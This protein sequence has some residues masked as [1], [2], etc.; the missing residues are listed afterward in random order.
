MHT[1]SLALSLLALSPSLAA[2]SLNVNACQ[3]GVFAK[4]SP[5]YAGAAVQPGVWGIALGLG[6]MDNITLMDPHNNYQTSISAFTTGSGVDETFDHPG[7]GGDDALLL[8][9]GSS[10]A[11]Q[12]AA[13]WWDFGPLKEGRYQVYTYAWDPSSAANLTEITIAGALEG[14]QIVGGSWT[15]AHAQGITYALHTIDVPV[16]GHVVIGC[17]ALGARGFVNGFQLVREQPGTAFCFGYGAFQDC[18]CGNFSTPGYGRGCHTANQGSLHL[19]IYGRTTPV[20]T[21][22]LSAHNEFPVS[23]DGLRVFVQGSASATPAPFGDG[24]NC[25]GG[26][27]LR[28]YAASTHPNSGEVAAPPPGWPSVSARSAGLGDPIAPGTTRYY[29]VYFRDSAS[30]FCAPPVGGSFNLSNAYELRW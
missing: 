16:G 8:D 25:I 17:A 1:R 6:V 9:D 27:L 2:Q 21:I 20:D 5:A 3:G 11:P 15:G 14:P 10:F 4:P 30:W 22:V 28:L 7:T 23:Q 12:G 13:M 24:V 18:P 29:T 19:A 26:T